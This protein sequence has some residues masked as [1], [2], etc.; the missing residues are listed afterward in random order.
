MHQDVGVRQG[1]ALAL[2]AA[3]E[4]ELA[5]RGR[6]A[7][8]DGDDVVRDELH[9]VVD[10]HAGRHGA[11]GAVDVEVDVLLRLGGQEQELRGDLVGDVIVDLLA[12]ED[13]ALAEQP[14]VDM[15]AEAATDGRLTR[16]VRLQ[17]RH[18]S[19][20]SSP[21]AMCRLSVSFWGAVRPERTGPPAPG[22]S[23]ALVFMDPNAQVGQRHPASRTVRSERKLRKPRTGLAAA[24][25]RPCRSRAEGP[26]RGVRPGPSGHCSVGF[27]RGVTWPRRP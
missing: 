5:H 25:Q 18:V 22:Y 2:G 8:T 17:I 19:T 14:V 1:E 24:V 12:E 21:T 20:C 16:G 6:H 27:A 11:T 15:V 26:G 4:Q 3:G 9:G 23:R 13:D 7:H 10:G